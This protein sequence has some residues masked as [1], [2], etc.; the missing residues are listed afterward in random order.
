MR[1]RGLV[2][3]LIL[4][5]PGVA[6]AQQPTRLAIVGPAGAAVQPLPVEFHRGYA[7]VQLIGFERIG[8]TV[9]SSARG[10]SAR[11][12]GDTILVRAGS[13]F[14]RWGAQLL[15]L[16]E[17]PYRIADEVWVPVQLVSDFLP[18]HLPEVYTFRPDGLVLETRVVALSVPRPLPEASRPAVS[19]AQAQPPRPT[20]RPSTAAATSAPPA[21]AATG[22][23][24]RRV[25]VIDPGHGGDDSGARGPGGVREKDVALQIGLA[26]ARELEKRPDLEVHLTRSEDRLV[27]LWERGERATEIKGERTGIFI[28]LHLNAGSALDARGFETYFLSEARTEHERRVA[29]LENEAFNLGP[30]ESGTRDQALNGILKELS[31]LDHQHW[32]AELAEMVQQDLAPIHPGPNRGV[33]QGPLA[34]ITNALMP[35]V[36]VEIGFISNA[37]EARLL[38]TS[39]FQAATARALAK[40]VD[41]FFEHYPPGS[42]GAPVSTR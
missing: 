31:N 28:S 22:P 38:S 23:A 16:T 19:R 15:Q 29:A 2:V 5:L 41:R 27:P 21:P 36:L 8:W 42:S 11:I 7:A 3:V 26:L 25:V 34:V 12:G 1:T 20:T 35:A 18:A 17:E 9:T 39:D 33:K 37:N 40:S 14:F 24:S 13:P 4:A 10:E 6:V 30:S 32:S